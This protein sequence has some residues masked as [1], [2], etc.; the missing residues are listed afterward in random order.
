MICKTKQSNF[1][2]CVLVTALQ[3]PNKCTISLQCQ[4]LLP[5]VSPH[6]VSATYICFSSGIVGSTL[7]PK[8]PQNS[9]LPCLMGLKPPPGA[10]SCRRRS[11]EDGEGEDCLISPPLNW[12]VR[13]I[14]ANHYLQVSKYPKHFK[15]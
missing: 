11:L 7:S 2:R 6:Q 10:R 3:T 13:H 9:G 5:Y 14:Q 8:I 12:A 15:Y 4:F 1:E